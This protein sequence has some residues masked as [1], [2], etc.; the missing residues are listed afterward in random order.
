MPPLFDKNQ[1]IEESELV[2][3]L[4]NKAPRIHKA[5]LISQ[6]VNPETRYLANFVEH[7]ERAETIDNISGVKFAASDEDSDTKRKKNSSK[8]KE[9]E[10]NGKKRHKKHSSL[11]CY[12]HGE[13]KIRTTREWKVLKAM[14]KDKDKPNY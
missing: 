4:A 11:Y 9:R 12:L 6:G 13:N 7:W 5:I 1:Q 14:T 10:E 3:S 8:F 2:D